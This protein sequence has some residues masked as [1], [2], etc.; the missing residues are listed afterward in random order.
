[1]MQ[2][3]L[4]TN[5]INGKKIVF[6]TALILGIL[7]IPLIAMQFTN[8]VDWNPFDFI[9][10][11]MLLGSTAF[12]IDLTLRKFKGLKNRLMI[13]GAVFILAV[14]FYIELAV[15]ILGTPFAGS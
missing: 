8:Q 9:I 5:K 6:I 2:E 7:S 11:A 10:M 4:N 14:L 1:M 12:L 3:Q 15:G 13:C